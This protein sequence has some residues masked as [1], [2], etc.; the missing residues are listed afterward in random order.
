[1]LENQGDEILYDESF[2]HRLEK[3]TRPSSI[4]NAD[5]VKLVTLFWVRTPESRSYV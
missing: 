2:S 1:M 4:G 3:S 5:S